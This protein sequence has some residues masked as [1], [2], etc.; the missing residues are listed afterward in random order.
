MVLETQRRRVENETYLFLARSR[1]NRHGFAGVSRPPL[2]PSSWWRRKRGWYRL[3]FGP[4]RHRPDPATA[5]PSAA[6]ALPASAPPRFRVNVS[7]YVGLET[8]VLE[9]NGWAN[10]PL[11][12]SR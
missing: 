6:A 8:L 11:Q 5:G 7:S 1:D 10:G 3:G 9:R 12:R 2:S 4:A